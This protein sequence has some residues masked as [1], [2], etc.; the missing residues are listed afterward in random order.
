ML[1]RAKLLLL[2]LVVAHSASAQLDTAAVRALWDSTQAGVSVRRA[3]LAPGVALAVVPDT[4][5]PLITIGLAWPADAA[6]GELHRRVLARPVRAPYLPT[7]AQDQLRRMG[8]EFTTGLGLGVESAVLT[9]PT[10][11]LI[12]GLR[13][14][15]GWWLSERIDTFTVGRAKADIALELQA[16]QQT[17]RQQ[18]TLLLRQI[19]APEGDLRYEAVRP[20]TLDS[21]RRFHRGI[22]RAT[23]LLLVGGEVNLDLTQAIV[24]YAY[25]SLGVRPG[26]ATPHPVL[27]VSRPARD[28]LFLVE[29]ALATQPA[30]LLGCLVPSGTEADLLSAQLLTELLNQPGTRWQRALLR[31]GIARAASASL[32]PLDSSL[33]LLRIALEPERLGT[34]PSC[35]LAVETE[36]AAL[37]DLTYWRPREVAAAQQRLEA[38]YEFSREPT[39][40][41]CRQLPVYWAQGQ[42]PLAERYAAALRGI[43]G[44][45]VS[46]WAARHLTE[47]PTVGGVVAPSGSAELEALLRY[48]DRRNHPEREQPVA[49]VVTPV[50]PEPAATP[51][52]TEPE[53]APE[54]T[55]EPSLS[56]GTAPPVWAD[57]LAPLT[58]RFGLG[59]ARIDSTGR[60]QL[61][62]LARLLR[63]HPRLRLYVD[64]HTDRVGSA[65]FNL[66]L[67]AQR[68]QLVRT[69]LTTRLGISATRLRVRSYG[70][71]RPV[72]DDNNPDTRGLNRRVEFQPR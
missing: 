66:Q 32:E 36:L 35:V 12:E 21:L 23:G 71:R 44:F 61:R 28:S 16:R 24:R 13:L 17:P 70:E 58:V 14:L 57:S 30:L 3:A 10:G 29:N 52:P 41:F 50:A 40:R 69:Y 18:L 47:L 6:T 56:V 37:V 8:G 11:R 68:A 43:D 65:A 34:V 27:Y 46:E 4:T 49:A 60:A 64:G 31:S 7:E 54:P 62:S 1:C 15:R 33:S 63:R 20:L 51:E 45:A 22:G 67:S 48:L 26:G 42:L 5:V 2:G 38:A 25:D 55:V 19:F 72:A 53:P 59:K 9:V 39:S